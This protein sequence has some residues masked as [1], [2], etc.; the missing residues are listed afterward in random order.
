MWRHIT[1]PVTV[2]G[3]CINLPANALFYSATGSYSLVNAT[4][5]TTLDAITAGYTATPPVN[6]CQYNCN[7]GYSWNGT[8]CILITRYPGC[9]TDDVVLSNGQ[10]WSACNA[11]A[12]LAYT[13]ATILDG[14]GSV[15]DTNLAI[16]N[17]L[18]GYFQWGRNDNVAPEGTPTTTLAS[19]GAVGHSDFI[20]NGTG[21][22]DWINPQFDTL[23]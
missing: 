17:I 5:G 18:G 13:G 11:G 1:P 7:S 10:V 15:S 14:T 21:S 19:T 23:W 22:F 3:V 8:S 4:G 20:M 16:R 6:T 2:S 12:T 9:D